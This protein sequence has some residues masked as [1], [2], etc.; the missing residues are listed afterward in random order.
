[1]TEQR[2]VDPIACFLTACE[3]ERREHRSC[4][5]EHKVVNGRR[6]H[7][8]GGRFFY[9]FD[10]PADLAL[11]D[12]S[13]IQLIV[14][15]AFYHGTVVTRS[16][17]SA[18]N[19]SKQQ[20]HALS[21]QSLTIAIQADL[22]DDVA[23][24]RI[25]G[26]DQDLLQSLIVRLRAI[27]DNQRIGSWNRE[28]AERVLALP[29]SSE[30][31]VDSQDQRIF[32]DDLTPDQ[33]TALRRCLTQPVTYVWGPPGTGKTVVLAALALQ[34]YQENKRVLIVSHTNHAV[35]GVVE[36]LC[37]RITEK[38]R[39]AVPEGS[40]LRVGTMVRES[41]IKQFGEQVH[42]ES[43][44]NRSHDKVS[45]RLEQLKRELSEVRDALFAASR[46][47]TLLDSHKQLLSE[48]D[49]VRRELRS[50][51]VSFVSAVK[52]VFQFDAPEPARRPQ[53][54]DGVNESV[55]LLESSV[56]QISRELEGCDRVSL[57]EQSVE[58]SS[59]QLEITE[60]IAVLEKFVRDL[61]I[62]LL[63]RARIIATTATHAMLSTK[64]LHTFDAVLIDEASMLPLPLCFLLSG[65]A[66]ERVIIA[67][68][69]R[70]LPAIAMS[71]SH[72]VR[73]WYSRD[74]FE[75]AGVI[76]LVDSSQQH[77]ALV[78]L[79]TQFRSH[80]TLCSLINTRFYGGI[81]Q[82]KA[83]ADSQPM[84][85]ND[86]LTY[87][88]HSPIVLVDTA[89]LAPWGEA[90]NRSKSNL[91]HALL[92]RKVALL[93]AG[94]GLALKPEALGVITPYRP[95]ANLIRELLNESELGANVS[96]GTVHK[97]QG[98]ERDVI[99]LDLTES[100]PH[101]AGNF[102]TASSLRETGARLLNVA[103]SRAK[104]HLVVIGN[105]EYLRAKL[106]SRHV[107]W[108]V[109]DDLQRVGYQL[110]VD[111]LIGE[112]IFATPPKEVCERS[113]VL[114][115]QAF[116][117]ELFLPGLITDLIEAQHEV[118]FSSPSVSARVAHVIKSVLE[119]RIQDG[120]RVTLW[121]GSTIG[122]SKDA[123]AVL[124]GL[125][126]AGV[127]VLRSPHAVPS[128]V[129]IDSEVVWVGSIAPFDSIAPVTGTMTRCVSQRAAHY[130]LELMESGM[131]QSEPKKLFAFA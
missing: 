106:S 65:Q 59:R 15:G 122:E 94:Q 53:N 36:S 52:R 116:D 61:R 1:M 19:Q 34:L 31:G 88:N 67:G 58:L 73:Q 92:V 104:R 112:P 60:A 30:P 45:S 110:P 101:Q 2:E 28:L 33:T 37:K 79:T 66:R 93:L 42:L 56:Q 50:T 38:G 114:A 46:K 55:E 77:P 75:C 85:F 48:L 9:S 11:R 76:D 71:D 107:M 51:D 123:E 82:T 62:S 54:V 57:S 91:M 99:I 108:G 8:E 103:L 4:R 17:L 23:S 120:L 95:Q 43:V 109:L 49:K 3:L 128:G 6:V 41:L 13:S 14:A 87:L 80:E 117:Q 126:G 78:T 10:A 129:V 125:Q 7:A 84:I 64:E 5:Q 39:T 40:I 47:M 121:I 98:S 32:P 89:P 86:P 100:F 124:R 12:D 26:Q 29:Q 70:Q 72:M 127:V 131:D 96:V 130:A 35:D 68:D 21:R 18:P 111:E 16:G 83:S 27:K 115:F 118:V 63:D 22:G 20:Q 25:E 105:L 81:L 119:K 102:F 69:F 113:G 24:A 74:V 90:R 44:M 97:F